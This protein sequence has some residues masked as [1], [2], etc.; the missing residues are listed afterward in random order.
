MGTTAVG[1]CTH[2]YTDCSPKDN[3]GQPTTHITWAGPSKIGSFWLGFF[4]ARGAFFFD[5][6][7]VPSL[8]IV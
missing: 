1:H 5:N 8:S 2:I 3:I 4:T 7:W 6:Q